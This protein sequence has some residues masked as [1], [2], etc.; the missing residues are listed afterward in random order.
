M[1]ITFLYTLAGGMMTVL[2]TGR[3]DQIAWRFLRLV[4]M[5][6]LAFC[7]G[8]G[9]WRLMQQNGAADHQYWIVGLG[10]G[11]A[12]AAALAICLAPLAERLPRAFR[13]IF[14]ISGMLAIAAAAVSAGTSIGQDSP[15]RLAQG[16]TAVAQVFSA[17]LIG[18]ITIAWLL[19]HA[20]L[21]ATKMTIAPLRHF[22][23]MLSWAVMLRIGFL[24]VSLGVSWW[25]SGDGAGAE[26]TLVTQFL[27]AWLILTLRIG[28]GLLAVG[29]FAYMVSDCV[30]LRSTQSA[31]GILYFGSVF[32]YVGEL[33]NLQLIAQYGWPL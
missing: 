24:V 32:A 4:A 28:V 30:R 23:R 27:Q 20:Y 19:G 9:V 10:F 3:P 8:N 1:A 31:T 6:A 13:S 25:V 15:H 29:L 21:T 18:S 22:S 26:P 14:L 11:S 16:V 2:A 33:A 12:F 17:F 5:T 7:V